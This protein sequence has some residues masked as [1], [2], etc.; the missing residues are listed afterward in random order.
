MN[1]K[2]SR[3]LEAL[4]ANVTLEWPLVWVNSKMRLER[5]GVLEGLWANVT[6]ERP[7]V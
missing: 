6:L 2:T 7:L 1:L 5:P 3:P 4:W